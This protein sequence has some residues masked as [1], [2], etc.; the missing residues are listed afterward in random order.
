MKKK[1]QDNEFFGETV[2]SCEDEGKVY[3]FDEITRG[4]FYMDKDTYD[5]GL[6]ASPS[7]LISRGDFQ[8]LQLVKLNDNLY[9]IPVSMNLGWQIF[10][11][12][13]R[14]L[15]VIYPFERD[16]IIG[17]VIIMGSVLYII[18]E[19]TNQIF[20][21]IDTSKG[22]AEVLSDNWFDEIEMKE[23]WGYSAY[24]NR[25][26]FPIIGTNEIVNFENERIEKI[27][28]PLDETIASV[29]LDNDGLW[30]L[31]ESGRY[32]YNDNEK[33]EI[34]RIDITS[35]RALV[36]DYIRIFSV[37]D[38]I[39]L[40][41]KMDG[42]VMIYKKKEKRW[43][44]VEKNKE[45]RFRVLFRQVKSKA[46]PF[47]DYSFCENKILL[48]PLRYRL[49]EIN[50]ETGEMDFKIMNCKEGFTGQQYKEWAK[51]SV[52]TNQKDIVRIFQESTFGCL[53]DLIEYM[54]I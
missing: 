10:N 33:S 37:G 14:H 29:C 27:W 52:Y 43:M 48:M 45:E 25:I 20:A 4:L 6:L 39:V 16:E 41:P 21:K 47:W 22:I 38:Y 8:V 51:N 26:V 13:S 44:C 11:L 7:E 35:E 30:I 46:I 2:R 12:V 17:N 36:C 49:V 24:L 19:Q 1:L 28:F 18:P 3:F 5:V 40:L 9:I 23:C 34:T 53:L 32:I 42:N 54:Q 50:L 31:P 15:N